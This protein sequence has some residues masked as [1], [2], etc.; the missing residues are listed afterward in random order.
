[1][2]QTI[3]K[4]MEKHWDIISYLFFG[5]CTTIVNYLIYIP[6]YNLWGLSATVSNM[7]A[8]V[9]AVAFAYLTNKPF[10]FRSNDWSAKTVIP[11][12]TRFVGCRIGS[13]AAETVILLLTVDLMGW[14]GNIWKLFTQVMVVVLNYIGSKLLVFRKK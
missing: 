13:G 9:V 6:C 10:V 3:K 7:I 2:I 8:W 11:E 4:L 12:L 1:M 5:V 14:N